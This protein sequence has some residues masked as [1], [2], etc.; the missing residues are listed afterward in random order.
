M[1]AEKELL[2]FERVFSLHVKP[3]AE[4]HSAVKSRRDEAWKEAMRKADGNRDKAIGI[5]CEIYP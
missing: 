3:Q 1:K 2:G 4:L 5:F